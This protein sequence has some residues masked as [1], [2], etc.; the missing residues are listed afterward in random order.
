MPWQTEEF[1]EQA[2]ND[3]INRMRPEEFRRLWENRWTSGSE[4]FIEMALID[5]GTARG[6]EKGLYNAYP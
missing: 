3:P 2:R 1:I 4:S 5:A 6:Q